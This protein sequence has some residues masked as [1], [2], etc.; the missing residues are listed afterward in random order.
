MTKIFDKFVSEFYRSISLLPFDMD[1]PFQYSRIATGKNF[2][3]RQQECNLLE[4]LLRNRTSAVLCAPAKTGKRSLIHQVLCNLRIGL[5][6]FTACETDMTDIRESAPFLARFAS[7]ALR[8]GIPD[9]AQREA[10]A[11]SLLDGIPV[12]FRFDSQCEDTCML[13]PEGM[14]D[15]QQAAAMLRLPETLAERNGT[16]AIV[17]LREFQNISMPEEGNLLELAEEVWTACR[18]TTFVFSG[19]GTN[20]MKDIFFRQKYFYRFAE[21]V[22]ISP[23]DEKEMCDYINKG[24][25]KSGKVAERE[26]LAGAVRLLDGNC[27]YINQLFSFC[28]SL[29]RGYINEGILSEALEMLVAAHEPRFMETAS[30]MTGHQA[31]LFRAILDGVTRFSS[32]EIIGKYRLNSS[33]NVRR[34]KDA[35]QK[36]EIITF[37]AEDNPHILDPL[38]RYWMTKY[39]F[40]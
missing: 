4:A 9:A 38:F 31:S 10:A 14:P 23:V 1:T 34:I 29:S 8:A 5:Y 37:D 15:R 32:G 3:G 21:K 30:G 12:S 24:F 13:V 26:L 16:D 22:E 20:A 11:H 6:S 39:F 28:D 19:S 33:A 35:L 36:K 40:R 18:K 27:W 17:V 25:Q 7:E 2:V